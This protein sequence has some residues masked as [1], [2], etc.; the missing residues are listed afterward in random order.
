[1][2]DDVRQQVDSL[3]KMI[4]MDSSIERRVLLVGEGI[5]LTTQFLQSVDDLQGV[6]TLRSLEG[7]VFA[8]V[9]QP[10]L[11]RLFMARAR[12]NLVAAV[13]DGRC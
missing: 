9:C 7:D 5:Q 13:D 6:A 2:E 11:T 10:L 8:E 1:M 12:C 3:A 4:T